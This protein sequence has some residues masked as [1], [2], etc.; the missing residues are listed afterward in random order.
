[1]RKRF[2]AL[3]EGLRGILLMV[4]STVL[5]G[6]MVVCIRLAAAEVHAFE[7]AFFRNFFGLVFALPLLARGGWRALRTTR[8][9]LYFVRCL[10]GTGAMLTGFWAL[11]HMPLV[12]AIALSYT[13][14]LFVTIGAALVLGEVV[15]ARRWTAVA[16]GFAGVLVI[17]RPGWVALTPAAVVA[18]VAAALT[19]GAA[20]SIKFLART[21][22]TEA[23]VVYMVLIMTPMS[24][25]AAAPVWIWPSGTTVLW[26]VLTGLFGTVAHWFLTRAY[27]LGDASA[28]TPITFVQ[29]PVVA[30]LSWMLFGEVIDAWTLAGA[31][32]IC[33]STLYIAHR[34]ARLQVRQVTDPRVAPEASVR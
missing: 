20:I 13:S 10:I 21:E 17:L 4:V 33:G 9:R 7:A 11:V 19:A 23:I 3:P 12:Q 22:S 15:R 31:A 16:V 28:L 5:F 30:V 8:L 1:V 27:K 18:L 26:L 24:L 14:P 32:I 29:L 34:E 6:F 25:V 2:H